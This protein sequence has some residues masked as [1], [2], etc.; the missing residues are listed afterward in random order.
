MTDFTAFPE[1]GVSL[2]LLLATYLCLGRWPGPPPLKS[3]SQLSP[4]APGGCTAAG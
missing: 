4:A 1:L 3:L 2:T